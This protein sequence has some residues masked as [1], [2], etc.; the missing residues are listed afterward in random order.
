MI[1]NGTRRVFG[2]LAVLALV[3][4]SR[5]LRGRRDRLV[6]VLAVAAAC[7]LA[8]AKTFRETA[9]PCR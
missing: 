2:L 7:T 5:M 6:F 1:K 3:S 9:R 4:D 8:G